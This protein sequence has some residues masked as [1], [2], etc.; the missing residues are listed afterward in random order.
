MTDTPH[1]GEI[2][3]PRCPICQAE[4]RGTP[5]VIWI[6]GSRQ[7]T[8]PCCSVHHAQSRAIHQLTDLVQR[9]RAQQD[10]IEGDDH[11]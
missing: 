3:F 2:T 4:I 8:G 5:Q 11:A 6:D 10:G 7:S 1:P 9:L